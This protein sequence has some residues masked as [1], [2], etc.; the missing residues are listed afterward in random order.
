[1][2]VLKAALKWWRLSL[3]AFVYPLL[4]GVVGA[5]LFLSPLNLLLKILLLLGAY[6]IIFFAFLEVIKPLIGYI[7]SCEIALKHPNSPGFTEDHNHQG[8]VFVHHERNNKQGFIGDSIAI[9]IQEL[10]NSANPIPYKV[11]HCFS[12]DDFIKVYLNLSTTGLWI[13]GH[14]NYSTLAFSKS[15]ENNLDYSELPPV[16]PKEFVAQLHCSNGGGKSIVDVNCPKDSILS[17]WYRVTFQNNRTIKRKLEE[18][19]QRKIK[20]SPEKPI[21]T[22]PKKILETLRCKYQYNKAK[23]Q[24]W[25]RRINAH[26]YPKLFRFIEIISDSR[27]LKGFSLLLIII[28]A[29]VTYFN[30]DYIDPKLLPIA[31]LE[32]IQSSLLLASSI[33]VAILIA[34]LVSKFFE[35]TKYR[36]EKLKEFVSLQDNLVK[37]MEALYYLGDSIER[38]FDL[39]PRYPFDLKKTFRDV[40]YMEDRSKKPDACAFVVGLRCFG[41]GF[42]DITEFSV[43]RTI[44]SK[45]TIFNKKYCIDQ[46]EGLLSR[47][48]HYKY[49]LEDLG[50]EIQ[51]L[52]HV[53]ILE[54][55]SIVRHFVDLI[56]PYNEKDSWQYLDFWENRIEEAGKIMEKINHISPYIHGFKD[57]VIR[58]Q[59]RLLMIAS[60]FGIFSPLILIG[61]NFSDKFEFYYTY[62]SFFMFLLT[63][64]IIMAKLYYEISRPPLLA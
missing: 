2:N 24:M 14:G 61:F 17:H 56:S 35:T 60:T 44:L 54:E 37:Y 1:M 57:K 51:A 53:K 42:S 9:L 19:R 64:S 32:S 15:R 39:K 4:I 40:E 23:Y 11:Y 38:E 30:L 25:K 58:T 62:I 20:P 43:S 16:E 55:Y 21:R 13:L 28:V 36:N 22:N 48:K 27:V 49:I 26:N 34:F 47:Q 8:I 50:F 33:L 3:V 63:F 7:E 29:L 41:R 52:H 5:I 6:V 31:K 59:M 46:L 12:K 10:R 18:I 45:K